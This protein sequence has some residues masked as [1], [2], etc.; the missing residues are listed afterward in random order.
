MEKV[1]KYGEKPYPLNPEAVKQA[2][3]PL[4]KLKPGGD[5][6]R[7]ERGKKFFQD[8][9]REAIYWDARIVQIT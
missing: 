4:S 2:S 6:R 8:F 7:L 9:N 5:C 3:R 1:V